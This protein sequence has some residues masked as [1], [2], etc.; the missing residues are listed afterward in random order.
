MDLCC[1]A[2]DFTS[3]G[4]EGSHSVLRA[5]PEDAIFSVSQ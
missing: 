3:D 2:D 4:V 5:G 1:L